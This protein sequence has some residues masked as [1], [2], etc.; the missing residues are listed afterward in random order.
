MSKGKKLIS[1]TVYLFLNWAL[2]SILSMLFWIVIGKNLD[3]DQYGIV[4]TSIQ[5]TMFISGITMLG[6]THVHRKIIPELLEKNKKNKIN[7]LVT[8]TFKLLSISSFLIFFILIIFSKQI[9][10]I[11]NLEEKIIWIISAMVIMVVFSQ[12]FGSILVAFQNMKK[13]FFTNLFGQIIKLLLIF[14]L[15]F[16]GFLHFGPLIALF[17][18]YFV[19]LILRIKKSF[20]L[21]KKSKLD[22]KKVHKYSL[23]AFIVDLSVTLN[24]YT[25]YIIMTLL[26]TNNLSS[27]DL[28]VRIGLFAVAMN[29]SFPIQIIPNVI[30]SALFPMISSFS[31][32]KKGKQKQSYLIKLITRY[33]L[34]FNLPLVVFMILSS[35]YII[36]FYSSPLYLSAVDILPFLLIT[37]MVYGLGCILTSYLYAIG[38]PNKYSNT[39]LVTTLI[40]LVLAIPLTYLYFEYGLIV[41]YL[42]SAIFLLSASI[43]LLRKYL[44]YTF[45]L[46]D[47][48]RMFFALTISSIFY[49]LFSGFIRNI[50]TA[51]V[52]VAISGLIYLLTLLKLNFYI[53]EDLKILDFFI[54]K[55]PF[56][57]KQA[58]SLRN[59]ISKNVTRSYL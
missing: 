3:P 22:K 44:K 8:Y 32:K 21:E 34:F 53:K 4:A 43:F 55:L 24:N 40:Y 49:L 36:T 5:V 38:K 7:S 35:K 18:C 27:E 57:K 20:F 48:G 26:I 59:F 52:F 54:E 25:Q 11:L 19:I 50:R 12:F 30:S 10:L 45:P 17:M 39:F 2:V 14:P 15:I 6:L 58:I 56:F 28:M 37:S 42:I 16:F 47:I 31:V 33:S 46:K 1:N 51:I 41:S 29:I 13:F 23:T 9:G